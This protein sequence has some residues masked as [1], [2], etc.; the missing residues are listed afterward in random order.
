ME[1][2][3][4][5]QQLV[6]QIA[7]LGVQDAAVLDAMRQVPRE[8]FLPADLQRFAYQNSPQPIG[9]DQTMSQPLVVALMTE[10]LHLKPSDR[11]LEIG[12][13]SGYA[14]AILSRLA[15]EVYTIER[16][17]DLADTARA[18]LREAGY[19]NVVVAHGD[20]TLGWPE[21]MMPEPKKFDA[22]IVAAGG[23]QVPRPL[24]DQLRVGGRLVMPVG[25]DQISQRLV[26]VLKTTADNYVEEDLG[27]VR[28]VPLVGEAGWR[29]EK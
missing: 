21:S 5:R 2:S 10:A 1:H 13:G 14:A 7:R 4:E 15:R 28:F 23:P 24:L 8:L 6:E 12:T 19:D 22:I 18:Q 20:G 3:Q 16:Y 27:D 25:N 29:G 17:R 11:V 26:R 9:N